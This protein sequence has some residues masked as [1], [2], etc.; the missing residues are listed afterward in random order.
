R[1]GR[2]MH[3]VET[4]Q[5]ERAPIVRLADRVAGYFVQAIVALAAVTLLVW[6]RLDASHAID[7][8]VALLVVTCPCALGMATPLAVSVALGRAAK[9]GV[10]FKSG[11]Y[12]EALAQ[13]GIMVFD[14]T[15]TLTAGEP[16]LLAWAG[17]PQLQRSLR[18]I[19]RLSTHPLA[20]SVQRA[21]PENQL[22]VEG[23]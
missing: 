1:L 3:S 18:A 15:G 2:L 5:R 4:T 20:R 22:S 23:L 12:I 21:F 8:T 16:E 14:K 13:P 17:D 11:E 7:H 19:E 10:L 9:A 6:W